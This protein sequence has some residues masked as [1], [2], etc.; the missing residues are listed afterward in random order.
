MAV[1]PRAV[2]KEAN[3]KCGAEVLPVM[4]KQPRTCV[5]HHISSHTPISLHIPSKTPESMATSSTR[6]YRTTIEPFNPS[7][8]E[9]KP[10]RD[11]IAVEHHV[12]QYTQTKHLQD[13]PR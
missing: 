6:Q 9:K 13:G 12:G 5:F 1:E 3:A 2:L 7:L 11:Q 8:R 10:W 4:N